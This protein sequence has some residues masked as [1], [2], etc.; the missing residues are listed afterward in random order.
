MAGKIDSVTWLDKKTAPSGWIKRKDL[1]AI[2]TTY[3][4]TLSLG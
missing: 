2:Y 1:V 3:K 4:E